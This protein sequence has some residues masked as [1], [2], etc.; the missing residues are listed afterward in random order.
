MVVG[1]YPSFAL[2]DVELIDSSGQESVCRKPENYPIPNVGSV[3]A[4]F[5]HRQLP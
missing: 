1:G 2:D 3:C 5:Q 4:Y